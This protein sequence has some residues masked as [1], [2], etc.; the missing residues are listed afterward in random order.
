MDGDVNIPGVITDDPMVI[1]AEAY[2]SPEYAREERDR[3][4]LK[5]WQIACRE[6]ELPKVGDYITYE[7][8]DQ[9]VI[10]VRTAPDEIAAYHNVCMH[11]GRRLADGCGHTVRFHCKFHGWQWNLDGE[12]AFVLDEEEWGAPIPRERIRLQPVKLGRWAGYV[13]VNLDPD[14]E[15]LEAHLGTLPHWF[16]PFEIG[17]MR[18]KWRKW[19]RYPCNWKVA[20]EAFIE[21]Y[22]APTTHPQVLTYGAGKTYGRNEGRHTCMIM[23]NVAG[24]GIGTAISKTMTGDYRKIAIGS[25]EQQR[26][27]VGSNYTDTLVEAAHRLL[28]VL[29]ETAT[30]PEVSA[31]MMQIAEDIDRQRG[32]DWPQVSA[33]HMGGIGINWHIFP[34]VVMLPNRTFNFGFRFRPDGSNPDSCI[35]EVYHL[36]R[37]PEG[38]EPK[39]ENVECE[40]TEENWLLLVSQDFANMPMVQQGMKSVAFRGGLA[41]PVQEGG[42]VNMHRHLAKFMGGRGAPT[43]LKA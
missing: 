16:D 17:K 5:V 31:K 11:R 13:F 8:V 26:D 34:N 23:K 14:C 37:F 10:V 33:E 28:D 3:L 19:M 18:Y 25:M 6:E 21:A 24:G 15:P 20:T 29:P 35:F 41:N 36:E 7:I 43:P 38:Q 40:P 42:V 2:V 1:P 39:T 12:N 32:I 9:S 22:H 4:W 27:T 30:A